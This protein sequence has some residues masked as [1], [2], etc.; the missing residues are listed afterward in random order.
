MKPRAPTTRHNRH[1]AYAVTAVLIR[2]DWA[3]HAGPAHLL[4][5][6]RNFPIPGDMRAVAYVQG[7]ADRRR[8]RFSLSSF[9]IVCATGN[10]MRNGRVDREGLSQ[11]RTSRR[12]GRAGTSLYGH[13]PDSECERRQLRYFL[14]ERMALAGHDVLALHSATAKILVLPPQKRRRRSRLG[15]IFLLQ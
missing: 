12:S 10:R 15:A 7:P 2:D 13:T 3:G 11:G 9:A 4:A 14:S 6:N 5:T 1:R 8:N